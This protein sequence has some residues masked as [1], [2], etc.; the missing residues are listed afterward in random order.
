MAHFAVT[1]VGSD[2]PGI[3]AAVTKTLVDHDCNLEDTS[4]S[5]LRGHF[6]MMLVVAGPIA[7]DP[8]ALEAALVQE[9]GGFDLVVAVRQIDDA[10]PASPEGDAWTVAVYGADRPGIVHAITALLAD[11][12]VNVVDLTTRV[13]G[14]AERPVYAMVLEVTLPPA[15][16]PQDVAARLDE[17]AAALG[18]ECSLHPSEADIL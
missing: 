14:D 2:R 15:V 9:T 10:V 5:I 4:M 17:Q 11:I 12:G 3:V 7:L 16:S 1:A 18:V 6:A 8:S 13:I